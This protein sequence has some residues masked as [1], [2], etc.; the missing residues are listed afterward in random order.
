VRRRDAS[1]LAQDGVG[2]DLLGLAEDLGGLHVFR[3]TPR[4]AFQ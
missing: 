1:T 3:D 2:V 4:G